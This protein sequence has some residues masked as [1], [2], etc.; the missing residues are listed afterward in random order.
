MGGN[1]SEWCIYAQASG[2]QPITPLRFW[3]FPTTPAVPGE[4]G[5]HQCQG[6]VGGF[7]YLLKQRHNTDLLMANTTAASQYAAKS[8]D[9]NEFRAALDTGCS[10]SANEVRKLPNG[11]YTGRITGFRL[12]NDGKVRVNLTATHPDGT[13]VSVSVGVAEDAKDLMSAL[14][15][16]ESVNF[17]VSA[18]QGLTDD[19]GNVIRYGQINLAANTVNV[20]I[21]TTP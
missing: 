6:R 3:W 12:R 5:S 1:I 4:G 2:T 7:W 18:A 13:T 14:D 8:I 9:V 15:K 10:G 11:T 20:P 16:G 21:V 19:N 17:T